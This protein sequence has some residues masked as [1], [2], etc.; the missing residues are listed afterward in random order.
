MPARHRFLFPVKVLALRY[1][2]LFRQALAAADPKA[3]EALPTKVWKQRWVVHCAPAGSGANALSYLARYVFKTATGNRILQLLPDG[4]LCWPYRDSQTGQSRQVRLQPLEFLRRFLEHVL[5]Q[6]FHRVR[7]FG[8]F[9][10]AARL[11]F[12]RVRALLQQEPLL[13]AAQRR[14]WLNKEETLSPGQPLDAPRQPAVCPRCRGPLLCLGSWR[15]GQSPL[16]PPER[17]PP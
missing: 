17:A 15:P 1:R 9:H 11:A 13:T 3:L 16:L 6:G 5:P 8:W 7:L 10:P 2:T 14:S 12:N 4:R